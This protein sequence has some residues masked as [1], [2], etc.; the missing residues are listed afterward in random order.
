MTNTAELTPYERRM[1]R[2][3]QRMLAIMN[4][5]ATKPFTATRARRRAA[6]AAHVTVTAAV[7]AVM[8]D[9]FGKQNPWLVLGTVIVGLPLWCIATG[10]INGAT[11]G[12]VELRSRVL[13][14]RQLAERNA[15][16]TRAHR[17][18]VG[19]LLSAVLAVIGWQ[20][21][22]HTV[23]SGAAL[24]MLIVALV[25]FWL[26]PLWTAGL[27]VQDEVDDLA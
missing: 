26:M 17:I 9:A 2:Y 25:T 6:V 19:L 12:L 20:W 22:G 7:L 21:A 5:P 15:I 4:N 8:F 1:Q 23:H 11:R 10:A 14:E 13:D 18:S 24:P 3:D 16:Y 27:M